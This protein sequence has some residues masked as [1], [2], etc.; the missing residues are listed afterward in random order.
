[1]IRSWKNSQCWSD[2]KCSLHVCYSHWPKL[3]RFFSNFTCYW[4]HAV[5]EK[6]STHIVAWNL[7]HIQTYIINQQRPTSNSLFEAVI[8]FG[9]GW[10]ELEDVETESKIS[11][12]VM[13]ILLYFIFEPSYI[14]LQRLF[15]R[16]FYLYLWLWDCDL[17]FF[18]KIGW[19]PL[20]QWPFWGLQLDQ[21]FPAFQGH[22]D[23]HGFPRVFL[24]WKATV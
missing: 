19:M 11:K 1:M 12:K 2:P 15:V 5:V 14:H 22:R 18:W 6:I 23:F 20:W 24:F 8:V 16:A 10:T 7:Q 13:I 21:E 9:P 4:S 17:D 3:D